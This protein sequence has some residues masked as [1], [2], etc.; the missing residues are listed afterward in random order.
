MYLVIQVNSYTNDWNIISEHKTLNDYNSLYRKITTNE[1]SILRTYGAASI[2][3]KVVLFLKA[4]RKSNSS[5]YYYNAIKPI[6]RDKK[7]KEILN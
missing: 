1:I 3:D 7:I 5:V 6:Y 2:D 4:I